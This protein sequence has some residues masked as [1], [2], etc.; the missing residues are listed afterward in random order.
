[1]EPLKEW[2]NVQFYQELSQL[3]SD[4]YPAFAAEQFCDDVM[5]GLEP[6]ALK[7][8]LRHTTVTSHRYL[9]DNYREAVQILYQIAPKIENGFAGMFLPDFVSLYGLA[10]V[11]FSLEALKY[12]TCFSSS[13]FAIRYFLRQDLMPISVNSFATKPCK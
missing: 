12:F 2:F 5:T 11:D 6:M 8:R 7:E 13:E 1:M 4:A 10:D 9:P 3:I